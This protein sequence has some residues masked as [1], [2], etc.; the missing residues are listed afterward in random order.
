LIKVR[1]KDV[2][3]VFVVVT[4]KTLKMILRNHCCPIKI[5]NLV[6]N[7]LVAVYFRVR[8]GIKGLN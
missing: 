7:F 3:L 5:P 1:H 8:E 2:S 4:L 6:M